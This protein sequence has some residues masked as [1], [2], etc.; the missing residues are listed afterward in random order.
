MRDRI[1]TVLILERGML[2]LFNKIPCTG[3]VMC[4]LLWSI[5][6]GL[7]LQLDCMINYHLVANLLFL[8]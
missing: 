3:H 8:T 7:Q 5:I 4:Q 1:V 6:D 2:L